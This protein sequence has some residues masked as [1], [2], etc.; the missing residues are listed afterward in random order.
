MITPS[1]SRAAPGAGTGAGGSG[2]PSGGQSAPASP[3]SARRTLASVYRP[4]RAN[5]STSLRTRARSGYCW[6]G[7]DA[8]QRRDAWRCRTGS[9]ILD[10]CFSASP[11]ARSVICPAGP[12]SRSALRLE[13]TRALPHGLADKGRP[14]LKEQPWAIELSDGRRALFAS[15]ASSELEGRRLDYFF[16]PGNDE[17]LW[18]Y[19]DR[20][21]QLW[22]ILVAP[23]TAQRLDARATIRHAWM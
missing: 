21:G 13:L 16:G 7:S 17:G 22:T 2:S 20:T 11:T 18:G 8:A 23:F 4:M 15:G 14:S 10:P 6:T 1:W 12:W 3:E 9:E 19:P 5:G